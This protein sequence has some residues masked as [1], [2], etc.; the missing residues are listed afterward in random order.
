MKSTTYW[1]FLRNLNIEINYAK[2]SARKNLPKTHEYV[3]GLLES[4]QI[5]IQEAMRTVYREQQMHKK[6]RELASK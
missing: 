4:S 2:I 5:L 3:H 1:G 6:V